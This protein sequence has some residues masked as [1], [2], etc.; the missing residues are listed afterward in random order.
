MF[1]ETGL[2]ANNL[3][4]LGVFSGED[5]RYTY[6][7]G[8][9]VSIIG[10]NYICYDFSGELLSETNETLELKWFDID[11]LPKEISPP[12]RKPLRAFIDFIK[13]PKCI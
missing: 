9:K 5:M 12:D 8:D 1:E 7:N 6:P 10:I 4:F 13:C 3:E 2:I 11:N